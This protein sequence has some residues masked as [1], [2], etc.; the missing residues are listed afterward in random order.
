MVQY[1]SQNKYANLSGFIMFIIQQFTLTGMSQS[2]SHYWN[3]NPKDSLY[4][5]PITN[6]Y[7][8]TLPLP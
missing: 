5:I 2:A 4:K 1:H 3:S 8:K 7:V 6:M